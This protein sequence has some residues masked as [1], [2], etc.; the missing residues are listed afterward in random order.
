M[1][2]NNNYEKYKI[3]TTS[4]L[5]ARSNTVYPSFPSV[6]SEANPANLYVVTPK[7]GR[8]Y[9]TEEQKEKIRLEA[10]ARVFSRSH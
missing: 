2:G 1:S 5:L 6:R 7:P 8:V 9:F 10:I 4:E 3:K